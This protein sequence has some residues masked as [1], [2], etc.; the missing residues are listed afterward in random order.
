MWINVFE[1][2]LQWEMTSEMNTDDADL[3]DGLGM[4]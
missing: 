3:A 4:F 2:D 1:W